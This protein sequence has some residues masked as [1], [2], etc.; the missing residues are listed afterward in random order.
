MIQPFE[1]PVRQLSDVLNQPG[2]VHGS[3]LLQHDHGGLHKPAPRLQ[4]VVGGQIG[5][6]PDLR[7]NRRHDGRGAMPVSNIILNND[8]R[9]IAVL[10]GTNPRTKVCVVQFSSP[11]VQIN[12]SSN[13][14]VVP[15]LRANSTTLLDSKKHRIKARTNVI[16]MRGFLCHWRKLYPATENACFSFFIGFLTSFRRNE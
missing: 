2:L 10:L 4:M 8:H 3:D 16:T 11:N 12:G 13:C 6:R 9:A 14:V 1:F 7:G 5:F 15:Y